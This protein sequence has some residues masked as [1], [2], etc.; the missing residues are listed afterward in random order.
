MLETWPVSDL[1]A[2]RGLRDRAPRAHTAAWIAG[3]GAVWGL[4][5]YSILWEGRPVVVDRA[6]VESPLGTLLLLPVRTVLTGIRLTEV[7]LG[8]SFVLAENHRWIGPVA[9]LVGAAIAAGVFVLA[10]GLLRRAR[11]TRPAGGSLPRPRGTGSATTSGHRATAEAVRVDT[12]S[13][14]V[15]GCARTDGRGAQMSDEPSPG[16]QALRRVRFFEDL[17]DGDLE[18]IAHIGERRSFEAGQ[19]IVEKDSDRGGLFIIVSGTAQLEAGGATHTLGPGDFVGEMALLSGI[20]RTATVTATEPSEAL[21]IEAMYFKPFLME[22]PSVAVALLEGVAARLR[23]VQ[24]RI[25][26]GG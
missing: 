6:F 13:E 17:T 5:G 20:R 14:D 22:N 9:G 25:D 11:P 12:G 1:D 2:R 10:R 15:A 21:V 26:R 23:E 3:L 7:L 18:R 8:R 19:A 16:A 24:D 4:L